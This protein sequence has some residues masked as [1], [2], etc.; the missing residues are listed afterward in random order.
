MNIG[1]IGMGQFGQA[2][3]SLLGHN[4]YSY[5]IAEKGKLLTTAPEIVF[6]A[7]PTQLLRQALVDNRQFIADNTILVNCS[8][9]IEE[10]THLLPHQIVQ[11]FGNFPNYTSLAGPTFAEELINCQP[12]C[13]SL[14]HAAAKTVRT[15]KDLLE[16]EYFS[17]SVAQGYRAL[18]LA[19]ALKN[20]YAI[21]CG[22]AAG[23]GL[24]ANTQTAIILAA[25]KEFAALSSAMDFDAPDLTIPGMAGDLILTCS[26]KESRNYTYGLALAKKQDSNPHEGA[27]KTVEGYH[28]CHSAAALAKT[29]HASMPLAL[30]TAQIVN[31]ELIPKDGFINKLSLL[32]R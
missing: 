19:A 31:G 28:T 3:A 18:E 7:T 8:K 20:V 9:G 25:L 2:I 32:L 4:G 29:H 24:G 12:A 5:E 17:L 10:G 15:I 13:A 23:M 30:L 16:T 14:G 27:T 6:L 1:M 26:S 22:Y 21:L 11:E